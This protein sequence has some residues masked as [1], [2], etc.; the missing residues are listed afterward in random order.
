MPKFT[1]Y[2]Y[3]NI[4]G[5]IK[6]KDKLKGLVLGIAI[7]TM[8]TGATAF[9]TSGTTNIKVTIQKLGIFVDGSKKAS[10]DA[11]IYKGTTYVPARSVSNAIGKEVGLVNGGLYIGKQ[12]KISVTEDQ[13][14]KL[15]KN[16]LEIG[17]SSTLHVGVDHLEGNSYVVHVYEVVIDDAKTGDGHTA[18][19]GWYYVDKTSGVITSMF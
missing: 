8:L 14:I 11:I 7:G 2:S 17:S 18:T 16:K 13:A 1:E 5:A 19:W 6:M 4:K 9:A 15:V 10:A 3:Q 12:P